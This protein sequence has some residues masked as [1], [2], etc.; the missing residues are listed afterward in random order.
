MEIFFLFRFLFLPFLS[1]KEAAVKPSQEQDRDDH[2]IIS[3]QSSEI[4]ADIYEQRFC[5]HM[6]SIR[7]TGSRPAVRKS[8]GSRRARSCTWYVLPDLKEMAGFVYDMGS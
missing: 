7:M 4:D 1:Y 2:C 8:G 3:L 6:V 5:I